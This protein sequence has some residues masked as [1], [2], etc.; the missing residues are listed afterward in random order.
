MSNTTHKRIITIT[1]SLMF[2]GLVAIYSATRELSVEGA[3]LIFTADGEEDNNGDKE[4]K[5]TMDITST[6]HQLSDAN[7]SS[8]KALHNQRLHAFFFDERS[9]TVL[10]GYNLK[11]TFTDESTGN[12]YN[13]YTLHG[14]QTGEL[15][16]IQI[17]KQFTELEA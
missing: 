12:E 13:K 6:G 11:L 14:E 16:D 15:A 2:V 17:R 4:H 7:Y 9:L 3:K 5:S 10:G 1:I 8:I